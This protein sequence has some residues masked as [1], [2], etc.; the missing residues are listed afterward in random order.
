M[1][2]RDWR[3]FTSLSPNQD[4]LSP[5]TRRT[6]RRAGRSTLAPLRS[7]RL[8]EK[9]HLLWLG[10]SKRRGS[11]EAKRAKQ[12]QTWAGWGMWGIVPGPRGRYG[13]RRSVN[14]QS[15]PP[16]FGRIGGHG[17]PCMTGKPWPA[18]GRGSDRAEREQTKPTRMGRAGAKYLPARWLRPGR[19][20][21]QTKPTGRVGR[22]GAHGTPCAITKRQTPEQSQLAGRADADKQSQSPP[23]ELRLPRRRDARDGGGGQGWTRQTKPTTWA[24]QGLTDARKGTYVQ[25]G[26]L[27]KQ[28]QP[29]PADW[30]ECTA[31]TTRDDRVKQ[32]Q[33]GGQRVVATGGDGYNSRRRNSWGFRAHLGRGGAHSYES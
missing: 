32:S 29:D 2:C 27:N 23:A 13:L 7:W 26:C 33:R 8:C 17:P 12:S 6:Q 19:V 3:G 31:H 24:G 15:Q 4:I 21:V 30:S 25:I 18:R 9:H 5:R 20:S 16:P 28:S 11:T 14:K 22:I 1:S 10:D